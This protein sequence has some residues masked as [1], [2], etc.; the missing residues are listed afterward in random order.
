MPEFFE[1][2]YQPLIGALH[3]LGIAWFGAALLTDAPKLRRLG[4][5]WMLGTGALLFAMNA[6]RVYASTSFRIKLGLLLT[7]MFVRR[8]RWLILALWAAVIFA[9]R[10]IA[11][12]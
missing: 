9:A 6:E 3:V 4:L 11:Y 12:F 2:W 10:G 8:P 7:L 5:A 1:V